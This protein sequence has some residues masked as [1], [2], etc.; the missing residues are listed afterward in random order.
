M[1]EAE[2]M[3]LKANL[4]SEG[5]APFQVCILGQTVT[6]LKDMVSISKEI[7][8]EHQRVFAPSVIEPSFGIGRFIYCLYEHYFNT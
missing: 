5:K 8:K 2:D 3:E 4:E 1:S 6:L 7:K